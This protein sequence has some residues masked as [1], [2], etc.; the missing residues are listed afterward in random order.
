MELIENDLA[1]YLNLPVETVINRAGKA[2][3][4]LAKKWDIKECATEDFYKNNDTYLYDELDFNANP[5]WLSKVHPVLRIHAK[6]H[7]D[8]GCGIGTLCLLKAFHNESSTGY[9]INESVINF[10]RWRNNKYK[11]NCNFVTE[12]PD[13]SK[14]DLVTAIDTLEHI[15][16]LGKF[17][18]K[19]GDGLQSGALFYH[20]D[21]WGF[22]GQNPMHFDY[23]RSIEG[24]L[25]EA[26]FE[27]VTREWA[28]KGGFRS[29]ALTSSLGG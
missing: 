9:D 3:E 1:E 18:K 28:I 26:G 25:K 6:N 20:S 22:Q 27:V 14:F 17:L 13:L 21:C 7:L 16:D 11:Y 29:C 5:A 15:E 12:M 19:L 2:C 10:A 8:I 23:S 24:W 4:T